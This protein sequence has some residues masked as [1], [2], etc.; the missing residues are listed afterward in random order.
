ME[1][2][3]DVIIIGGGPG[4]YTAALYATRA[5]LDTL[6]L[7]KMAAGGQ[8]NL[9]DQ[10]DN[11]PGFDQG[12]AGYELGEKMRS[13]AERFGAKTK[14][15]LVL[16]ADLNASVKRI[17]TS[18]GVFLGKTVIISTGA[19]HRPLGVPKEADFVGRGVGYCATCDGMFFRNKTV[20]VVG[21]GNTAAG[22]A[23]YLS[24]IC[25]KVTLIHRRDTLRATK[26][27]QTQL[28]NTTNVEL[29]YNATVTSLLGEGRISGVELTDVNTKE[30]STLELDGLF[31]SVGQL[32]A[33]D[34]F[35]GHVDLD[36]NGYIV[37]DETTRTNIP[38]VYA[39][40][41][42]RTKALRQVITAAADGAIAAHFAEHYLQT[43]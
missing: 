20:A 1:H 3:Y 43:L 35:R 22:D 33:T 27:Y 4:G 21:G 24:R 41:D 5:G 13:G 10:I 15:T 18:D 40:G 11:Y 2:I 36:E 28:E 14:N 23:L 17:E 38:G 29:R 8:M 6:V 16:S 37:A 39:V 26:L 30:V 12:I 7:E 9:T 31:I 32:P 34:L 25:K 19:D 42:V